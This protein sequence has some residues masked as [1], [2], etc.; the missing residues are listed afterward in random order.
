M[1]SIGFLDYSIEI[2][3]CDVLNYLHQILSGYGK[4]RVEDAFL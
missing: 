3:M 2:I 1:L 4:L